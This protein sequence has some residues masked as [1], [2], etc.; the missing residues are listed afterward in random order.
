[1][2]TLCRVNSHLLNKHE[3]RRGQGPIVYRGDLLDS[4]GYWRS[5]RATCA[6]ACR[7]YQ[8][9]REASR[10]PVLG[11]L[12]MIEAAIRCDV[13]CRDAVAAWRQA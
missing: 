1:M 11:Q 4:Q 6:H 10:R 2:T 8:A 12:R 7:Q 5:V 3:R 9:H 13:A